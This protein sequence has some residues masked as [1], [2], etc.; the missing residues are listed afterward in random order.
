MADGF[1]RLLMYI[2]EHDLLKSDTR[3]S[4]MEATATRDVEAEIAGVAQDRR[5][6]AEKLA[7][8]FADGLKKA[9]ANAGRVVVDDTTPEGNNIADAIARFLVTTNLATSESS[10]LSD[11]HYRYTFDVDLARVS[12]IA[13]RAGAN[14]QG[15]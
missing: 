9:M 2:V 12:E 15:A 6:D 1:D 8:Y 5:D 7:P 10:E 11:G 4:E 14:I 3:E 13:G